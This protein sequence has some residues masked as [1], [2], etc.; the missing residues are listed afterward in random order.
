MKLTVSQGEKLARQNEAE[1]ARLEAAL[2]SA[3]SG[4][5][6]GL[7]AG[8]RAETAAALGTRVGNAW[9]SQVYPRA[10]VSTPTPAGFVWSRAAAIVNAF[11][12]GAVISS[13]DGFWL[14]VPLPAAGTAPGGRRWTVAEWE[15]RR[16]RLRYVYRKNGYP[17]LVATD[18]RVDAGGRFRSSL[19]TS[20]KT[21]TTYSRLRGR[22]SVPIFVL[23]PRVKLPKR[24]SLDRFGDEALNALAARV[25]ALLQR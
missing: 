16:G 6:D 23:V 21:G 22:A 14:T 24:L 7:K 10:G 4:A 12:T 5:T 15:R 11:D 9:R 25:D 19:T 2:R 1:I 18:A 3:V 8:L 17:L 13:K 20:R